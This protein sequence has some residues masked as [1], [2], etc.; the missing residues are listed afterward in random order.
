S[1]GAR[2]SPRSVAPRPR[3][4]ARASARA[5]RRASRRPRSG[6]ARLPAPA[7]TTWRRGAHR[8]RGRRRRSGG[9]WGEVQQ[10]PFRPRPVHVD[11]GFR[12]DFRATK[13][14]K[15]DASPT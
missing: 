11:R 9:S 13:A 6:E 15:K 3:R 2:A 14:G 1:R 4:D 5:A 8:G 12:H 7:P 10:A